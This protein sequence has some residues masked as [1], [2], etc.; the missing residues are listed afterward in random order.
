MST[1]RQT[2]ALTGARFAALALLMIVTT[3][4]ISA[5]A[6][7]YAT[8]YSFQSGSDGAGPYAGLTLGDSGVLYGTTIGGGLGGVGTAYKLTPQGSS[9]TESVLY[10]FS[11]GEDGAYPN[12]SLVFGSSQVLYGT[13]RGSYAGTVFELVPTEIGGT[14]NET[15]LYSFSTA[16]GS[17]NHTP[18]APVLVGSGGT[19]YTTTIGG[20]A[21]AVAPPAAPGGS[22]TGSVIYL[23]GGEPFAGFASEGGTLYGTTY[24]EGMQVSAQLM[25]SPRRWWLAAPGPRKQYTTLVQHPMVVALWRRLQLV[26]VASSMDNLLWRQWPQC[27]FS[28]GNGCGT[29]F[30]LTPPLAPG[31]AWTEAVLYSFSGQ[32]GDGGF[33]G[34]SVVLGDNG[35]LYGTTEYGGSAGSCAT[36]GAPVGCG[37][38]FQLTP[39]SEP[40]G[41]WTETVLHNFSGKN[42]DGAMPLAGLTPGS[43]GE[44]YGTASIGGAAGFGTV[45]SIKPLK[46][47]KARYARGTGTLSITIRRPPAWTE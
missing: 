45:F 3:R 11:G 2:A 15:V 44:F 4:N 10:A 40:G 17:N 46:A 5:Q 47:A 32:N 38:I 24:T 42:G 30:Q 26:R 23:L 20:T 34:G 7:T 37:T 31:D 22:W 14:W 41:A 12:A 33:P 13:T 35:V 43:N 16:R 6:A 9:W 39:P 25:N 18:W 19:L 36:P 27:R 1:L 21:V 28:L 8:L 29:V